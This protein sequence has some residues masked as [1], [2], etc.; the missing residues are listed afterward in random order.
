M[1]YLLFPAAL[2]ISGEIRGVVRDART[3]E[4]L[5]NVIIQLQDSFVETE[6][7]SAGFFK[8][9]AAGSDNL[10]QLKFSRLGY[11]SRTIRTGT[12]QILEIKLE[13][14]L[15]GETI[16]VTAG[17]RPESD[18][19][20]PVNT[21]RLNRVEMD[22][23]LVRT[24]PEALQFTN[25]WVQKTNHG[26]G[27]PIIRGLTGNQTLLLFNGI[28]LNNS[29]YRYGPNQ[30]LNTINPA[31]L[32]GIEVLKSSGSVQYG[33]D[34]LG[35]VVNLI[36]A[37]PAFSAEGWNFSPALSLVLATP[38]GQR[39]GGL[40]VNLA[41]QRSAIRIQI[42]QNHHG[43]INPGGNLPPERP[44]GY[45]ETGFNISA[46]FLAGAHS[47]ITFHLNQLIQLNVPRWDQV[48]QRGYAR[49]S[50]DPQIQTISYLRFERYFQGRWLRRSESVASWQQS[51]EKR[52]YQKAGSTVRTI[53]QDIV[54]TL[55]QLQQFESQPLN[56]WRIITGAEY[57]QDMIDSWKRKEETTDG[58]EIRSRGLYPDGSEASSWAI[59]QMHQWEWPRF[60]LNFGGRLNSSRLNIRDDLFGSMQPASSALV[61]NA[62]LLWRINRTIHL[63]GAVSS[64]FRAPNIN[65]MSTFGPFDYGI[66]VPAS[67]LKP[68]KSLNFETSLKVKTF[69]AQGSL[70]LFYNQLSDLIDRAPST[71]LDSVQ[72][73]G[74]DVYTKTNLAKARIIGAEADCHL[75]LSDKIHSRFALSY[76][77]GED[78]KSKKPLRRIPPFFGLSELGWRFETG[79]D[80]SLQWMFAGK[81]TRLSAGD[82]D[83]QRIADG[84]TPGWSIFNLRVSQTWP[85]IELNAR[86]ENLFDQA[87]R[88][89][90]SGVDAPGRTAW[91]G[92]AYRFY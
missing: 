79:A 47:L 65:D 88:V 61:G 19:D 69:R 63:S 2:L 83:D 22:K 57:Y 91:L 8:L 30:Y 35:G 52:I 14:T 51:L 20:S 39:Q 86:L 25:V 42:N 26:G 41:N 15:V 11:I 58:S 78:L 6:S 73:L 16:V 5:E 76:S 72:Y 13:S 60:V 82:K 45:D 33:S 85:G 3:S 53:E 49:Y 24:T 75:A 89:H 70:T 43:E 67:G 59:F 31:A 55:G 7:D 81:Q 87:Y 90:G 37:E 10:W 21:S 64:A 18:F 4:P 74:Q 46:R 50:F 32:D 92:A 44:S 27:S 48:A 34:A 40:Q 56:N 1:F 77:F 36:S 54:T 23:N 62:G 80:L 29:T 66:E 28:R 68:E 12:D 9:T 38:G 17:R 84:G 71:Y